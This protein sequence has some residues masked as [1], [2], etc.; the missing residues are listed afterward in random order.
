M[1][2][3][4]SDFVII[5][6]NP[7]KIGAIIGS[8]GKVIRE[9]IDVTGTKVDI[10][11]D[12]TVKVSGTPGPEMDQAIKWIK[13]LAGQIEVGSVYTGKIKRVVDF[14]LFVELVP[15]FDGLL[16]ISGVPR[17]KQDKLNASYSINDVVT[18]KVLEY[19]QDTSRVRL[20]LVD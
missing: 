20:E 7:K 2:N 13:T 4:N 17:E 5:K 3:L 11:D 15:G 6:V 1:S 12:G 16:H 10:E 14:G 18:V 8:R 9:I 19:N